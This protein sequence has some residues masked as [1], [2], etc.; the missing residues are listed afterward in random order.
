LRFE[1]LGD[2][3]SDIRVFGSFDIPQRRFKT[4]VASHAFRDF[5]ERNGY[6]SGKVAPVGIVTWVPKRNFLLNACAQKDV[7]S[8]ELKLATLHFGEKLSQLDLDRVQVLNHHDTMY[9][10]VGDQ[11]V[12]N[13]NWT[14]GAGFPWGKAKNLL[15][16]TGC[17][18]GQDRC[19]LTEE[20]ELRIE[21]MLKSLD[22]RERPT[23]IFNAT[24]KD[25]PISQEKLLNSKIRVFM[26]CP[27]EGLYLIRKYF[28]AVL[29]VVQSQNLISEMA[30]GLNCF[31]AD[32]D[33]LYEYMF[34]NSDWKVFCG[35]YK[36]YDQRMSSQLT[37]AAW[38]LLI[39]IAKRAGYGEQELE[40]MRGLADCCIFPDVNFFG[41]FLTLFGTNPS[42][43]PLTVVINGI[44]NSLYIRIAWY[45]IFGDLNHFETNVR[46]MTYGDDNMVSVSPEFQ[47]KFNQQTVRE[48]LA[49]FG[50]IY[51]DSRKDGTEVDFVTTSEM[52]FLKRKWVKSDYGFYYC[53]L[54]FA[55]IAKSLQMGVRTG[56]CESE[57]VMSSVLVGSVLE[58][59]QHGKE[60][61]DRHM[62]LVKDCMEEYNLTEWVSS[63]GGLRSWDEI[64]EIRLRGDYS[65]RTFGLTHKARA[66]KLKAFGASRAVTSI[67][68]IS[69]QVTDI[70]EG[71]VT[72]TQ[73]AN[74]QSPFQD[75]A[76]RG[77]T[78]S[79]T[80]L[81][82]YAHVEN[83]LS[84]EILNFTDTTAQEEHLEG[85]V[86]DE[87]T[88][89]EY[90]DGHLKDW[91]SRPVIID[92]FTMSE[93]TTFTAW[94]L[95][96]W[97]AY[98]NHSTIQ[99]K[100]K[101]FSRLR[102]DLHVK[103][104]VNGT[105]FRYGCL[106]ASY[107]PLSAMDTLPFTTQEGQDVRNFS[108]GHISEDT[109]ISSTYA[110]VIEYAPYSFPNPAGGG[111]GVRTSSSK[112]S[113]MARSQRY[114]CMIEPQHNRGCE[115]VLPFIYYR[116]SLPLAPYLDDGSG[117]LV[118]A[119]LYNLGTIVV[120]EI[121]PLRTTGTANAA[122]VSIQVYAWAEN[123]ELFGP[124]GYQTQSDTLNVGGITLDTDFMIPSAGQ[125]RFMPVIALDSQ[126]EVTTDT[127]LCG[128][129][130]DT[131]ISKFCARQSIVDVGTWR[132][133]DPYGR[134]LFDFAVVPEYY[135]SEWMSNTTATG[136]SPM[137]LTYAR[138][139]ARVM[140]TPATYLSQLFN[141]WRG[142]MV[143]RLKV[144]CTPFHS[145][146]LKIVYDPMFD[147]SL[148][149]RPGY[150]YSQIFD[151]A[152]TTEIVFKV[153]YSGAQGFLSTP[154]T[155]ISISTSAEVTAQPY[156]WTTYDS[157]VASH[158]LTN[159]FTN[160]YGNNY[161]GGFVSVFVENVLQ[162]PGPTQ[163]VSVVA[164]VCFENM[165]FADMDGDDGNLAVVS[166]SN[167]VQFSS[168][169]DTIPSFKKRG[170]YSHLVV[171]D[172]VTQSEILDLTKH[173]KRNDKKLK[174]VYCGERVKD[175]AMVIGRSYIHRYH[176][177]PTTRMGTMPA[178]SYGSYG[179][180]VTIPRFPMPY[181]RY[182]WDYNVIGD[183][184]PLLEPLTN[185][186]FTN[187]TSY[188]AACFLGHR[189]SVKASASVS[190]ISQTSLL[191]FSVFMSRIAAAPVEK[192]LSVGLLGMPAN[193]VQSYKRF[194]QATYAPGCMSAGAV[195]NSG[196]SAVVR[197][198]F[199]LLKNLRMMP[200]NPL[201]GCA[202]LMD[203]TYDSLSI[204]VKYHGLSA[205]SAVPYGEI[206]D[207][208]ACGKDFSLIGFVNVPE[209]FH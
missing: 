194:I 208:V 189:G 169:S 174:D 68:S 42:G 58:M 44:V 187:P 81:R 180:V 38:G 21:E 110:D 3:P 7:F 56:K 74:L 197:G 20:V 162:S 24:L 14:A 34:P 125:Q 101:G 10:C 120:E 200:G 22:K 46:M 160:E 186:S 152:D 127:T 129:D 135:Y 126:N 33:A 183:T 192:L 9:G 177:F 8:N 86:F 132:T 98:F 31:S 93:S 206:F 165:E 163:P 105:P 100:I 27:L 138:D 35:D 141:F 55:S 45:K 49:E 191:P 43:H 62:V 143:L 19:I 71:Y 130:S 118:C 87:V 80:E 104:I 145:G 119:S 36:N 122:P 114:H 202:P 102:C 146:R 149:M 113:R 157:G 185:T 15:L 199:P 40:R 166:F 64:L 117:N 89:D 205:T 107:K 70:C 178:N 170:K 25:E 99:P 76:L 115:M 85:D 67:L 196:T 204:S 103:F 124:T 181:G 2:V 131:S 32:W 153:P 116:D 137:T 82:K 173:V 97:A 179:L 198:R 92:S 203:G 84:A 195:H 53:P 13:I 128:V 83:I 139:C 112:F 51:T 6:I 151:I 39:E 106:M 209:I 4:Q 18:D 47:G 136:L 109:A 26:A 77:H 140:M 5:W 59:F 133:T 171:E 73:G 184:S 61:F 72:Q 28:L 50:V 63:K 158:P 30:I 52:S 164:S 190:L 207:S 79:Y 88:R 69:D 60:Q 108:G 94:A 111:G 23:M 41:D 65:L 167:L 66:E 142:D 193:N 188:L 159:N 123:V 57:D 17:I 172:F 155:A 29:A 150:Q 16:P 1:G 144:V 96:P 37:S 11:F 91:F 154:Q 156:A 134:K 78:R 121:A 48:S 54:E 168:Q 12:N 182:K 161:C 176:D 90:V 147:D 148:L 175:L 75:V 201:F 95:H